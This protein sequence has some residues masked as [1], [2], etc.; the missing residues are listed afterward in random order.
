MSFSNEL[1]KNLSGKR[2]KTLQDIIASFG[3]KS[4]VILCLL[5]MAIPALP[6][7]TGGIT[8][9]FEIITIFIATEL[10][11][12]RDNLWLPKRWL[13]TNLP[14]SVQRTALPKFIKAISWVEKYARPRFVMLMENS[15]LIRLTGA[16]ILLFTIFALLAPPFSGLD[17]LP[18]L[19]VVLVSLALIFNDIILLLVG[20]IVGSTGVAIILALGNLV[21]RLL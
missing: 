10:I 11:A 2:P 1:Q 8:H 12:G 15:L 19:G 6:L 5:L 13:K 7:P 16:A 21:L 4:F 14:I 9:I 17:T 20:L 3:K 18:S